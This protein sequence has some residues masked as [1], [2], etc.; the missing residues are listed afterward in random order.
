MTDE[1]A[2]RISLTGCGPHRSACSL[3]STRAPSRT[4]KKT[5]DFSDK[6]PQL[7]QQPRWEPPGPLSTGPTPS[8]TQCTPVTT[9]TR[10]QSSALFCDICS[11]GKK[12]PL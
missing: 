2:Q 12:R 8:S 10:V 4:N 5:H 7:H 3:D 11:V 9:V 6:L 1:S